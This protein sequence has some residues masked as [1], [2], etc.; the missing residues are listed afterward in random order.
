MKVF[1]FSVFLCNIILKFQLAHNL[2]HNLTAVYNTRHTH[3]LEVQDLWNSTVTIKIKLFCQKK[4]TK[5][6]T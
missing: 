3:T 6:P 5:L 4:Q 1:F 2:M